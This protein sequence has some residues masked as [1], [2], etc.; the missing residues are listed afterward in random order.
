VRPRSVGELFFISIK[1]MKATQT[2]ADETSEPDLA[3]FLRFE[4][5]SKGIEGV[6][7]PGA[8]VNDAVP[9]G[10]SVWGKFMWLFTGRV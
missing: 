6:I 1:Q 4:V 8:V 3:D 2:K 9:R 7:V 5:S 10:L